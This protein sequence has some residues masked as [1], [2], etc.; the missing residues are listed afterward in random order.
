MIFRYFSIKP[1]GSMIRFGFEFSSCGILRPGDVVA[2]DDSFG[3]RQY[4]LAIA[5]KHSCLKTAITFLD[6]SG[7]FYERVDSIFECWSWR[8]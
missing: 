3:R 4:G 5:V 6:I 2:Y 8:G 1:S 7:I